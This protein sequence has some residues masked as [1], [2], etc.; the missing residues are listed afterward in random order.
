LIFTREQDEMPVVQIPAGTF[1]MGANPDDSAAHA[2][3]RPQHPVTLDSFYLD[4]YEVSVR[5][6]AAFLTANGSHAPSA[7]LGFTCVKTS[8][9]ALDSRLIWNGGTIYEAE[10]GFENHPINFVTWYG[11]KAYCE[12][13]GGRLPTEAEWEYAARGTDGRRYPWG[14]EP[15]DETRA[16][17]SL[18]SFELLPVDA[19]PDGTSFFEIYGMAGSLWEWVGD[20]YA[21]DYYAA[22]PADNPT[23]PVGGVFRDPRVLRGGGWNSVPADL[24]ATARQDADPLNGG[25]FG[26]N[27]GFR[28]AMD[29]GD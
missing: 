23:G 20:W 17:F 22:S 2:D 26:T 6:Y 27:V 29:G 8:F 12:W 25:D 1:Q 15:A 28:C 18:L 11:A 9:E 24:R 3:E 5:Q 4:Q 10:P 14:D 21:E 13:V 16:I 7:C 19:L